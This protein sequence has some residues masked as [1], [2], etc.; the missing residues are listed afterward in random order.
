MKKPNTIDLRGHEQICTR[1]EA[2]EYA[3]YLGY[4]MMFYGYDKEPQDVHP[5]CHLNKDFLNNRML[6]EEQKQKIG[7]TMNQD[8]KTM[9]PSMTQTL[10]D[11]HSAALAANMKGYRYSSLEAEVLDTLGLPQ[12]EPS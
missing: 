1:K 5:N 4:S 10:L 11:L 3:A 2:E 7:A 12:R 9:Q 6:S 8:T